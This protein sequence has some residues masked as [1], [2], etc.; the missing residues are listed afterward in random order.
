MDP[1]LHQVMDEYCRTTGA[2]GD[3]VALGRPRVRRSARIYRIRSSALPCDA[4]VKVFLDREAPLRH[5]RRSYTALARYHAEAGSMRVAAPFAL[6][7][8]RPAVLMEWIEGVELQRVLYG[9]ARLHLSREAVL[10][11]SARWLAWFHSRGAIAM[12]QVDVDAALQRVEHRAAAIPAG[13]RLRDFDTCLALLVQRVDA[14]RGVAVAHGAVHGDFTPY[15]LLLAGERAYG[16]DFLARRAS[17]LV[18]DVNRMLVY[19]FA[20]RYA[21]AGARLLGVCGCAHDDWSAFTAHYDQRLLPPDEQTFLLFQFLEVMRRWGALLAERDPPSR[22]FRR[23][24]RQRLRT[25]A[26]HIAAL[27]A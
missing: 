21:P 25:Q 19:L 13:Q 9:P 10:A 16:I 12:Q 23:I 22:L 11:R 2:P 1:L 17:P 4:A 15:N 20:H 27:L 3:W 8:A 18:V 7:E 14:L 26:R 5:A 6:L 24:E